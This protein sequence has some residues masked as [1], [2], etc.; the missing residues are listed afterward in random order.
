MVIGSFI[1]SVVVIILCFL[2]ILLWF[3]GQDFKKQ[4]KQLF[5]EPQSNSEAGEIKLNVLERGQSRSKCTRHHRSHNHIRRE[6]GREER[7]E[8]KRIQKMLENY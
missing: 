7:K 8:L 6:I 3:R 2:S 5:A 4:L 1:F